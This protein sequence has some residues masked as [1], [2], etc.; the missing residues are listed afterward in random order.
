MGQC[1]QRAHLHGSSHQHMPGTQ[2]PNRRKCH[3]NVNRV[4]VWIQY[5]FALISIKVS[6]Y[7]CTTSERMRRRN[8]GLI[9]KEQPLPMLTSVVLLARTHNDHLVMVADISCLVGHAC[10]MHRTSNLFSVNVKIDFRRLYSKCQ[11]LHLRTY[12]STRTN[13]RA[14]HVFFY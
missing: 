2:K 7:K 8:V 10:M 9:R 11:V 13:L 5:T 12:T 4:W 14:R 1:A 3:S 6:I